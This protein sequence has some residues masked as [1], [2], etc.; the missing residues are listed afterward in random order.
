MLQKGHELE[1]QGTSMCDFA[2]VGRKLQHWQG[3][4]SASVVVVAV[5]VVVV[6]CC[7]LLSEDEPC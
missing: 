5:V 1:Q 3:P 2:I 4:C 7:P 6:R